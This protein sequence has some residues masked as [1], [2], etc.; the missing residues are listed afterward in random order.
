LHTRLPLAGLVAAE[1]KLAHYM[2]P[3]QLM[4]EEVMPRVNAAL[5]ETADRVAA[6]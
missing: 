2:S 5:G 4:A 6:E 3:R 1:I